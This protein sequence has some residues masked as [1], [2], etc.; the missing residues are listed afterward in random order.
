MA[1]KKKQP[2][3]TYFLQV[4]FI[5]EPIWKQLGYESEEEMV[6]NVKYIKPDGSSIPDN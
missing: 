5:P 1:K 2:N 6:E 3:D 4:T